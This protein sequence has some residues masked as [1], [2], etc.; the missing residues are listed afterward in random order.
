[1]RA[2]VLSYHDRSKMEPNAHAYYTEDE[3]PKLTLFDDLDV[4]PDSQGTNYY[5]IRTYVEPL[6]FRS[7]YRAAD[8]AET[9]SIFIT[10]DQYFALPL[11][12]EIEASAESIMFSVMCLEAYIN[13]FAKDYSPLWSTQWER[14]TELRDKW[15]DVP[16]SLG[17]PHC[18]D[19]RR[20]PYQY[21]A[22]IVKWRNDYLA[23]YK[24]VSHPPLRK[25]PL[26]YISSI[27]NIFNATNAREAIGTVI[28][29]IQR[30][31]NELGK[32]VP[33]W[34]QLYTQG[35]TTWLTSPEVDKKHRSY[36][37]GTVVNEVDAQIPYL[38]DK[39]VQVLPLLGQDQTA[40]LQEVWHVDIHEQEIYQ[41]AQEEYQRV[42]QL[43]VAKCSEV[44]KKQGFI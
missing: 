12:E 32:Q 33:S 25:K 6:F 41:K 24:H 11:A 18:F 36:T 21:F 9:H 23:H 14:S 30:I 1:M 40:I 2:A 38:K 3:P 42:M 39:L 34:V 29:M 15:I 17:H 20:S 26:G 4:E 35:Y 16:T 28:K 43:I 27:Y 22:Q 8:K 31:N 13:G 44:L 7:A 19:K 37:Y 5:T 10:N